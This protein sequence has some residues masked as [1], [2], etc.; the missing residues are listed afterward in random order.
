MVGKGF[1]AYAYSLVGLNAEGR[2]VSREPAEVGLP[3]QLD[4]MRRIHIANALEMKK[5]P[6]QRITYGF[7]E[8]DASASARAAQATL[9]N[10]MRRQL[11]LGYTPPKPKG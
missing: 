6:A 2:V 3:Q 4:M 1:S 8:H 11:L 7:A 5:P 10:A 9:A